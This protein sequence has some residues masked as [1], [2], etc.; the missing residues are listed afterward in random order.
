MKLWTVQSE[1]WYKTLL[2]ASEIECDASRISDVT[3]IPAYEWMAEQMRKRLGDHYIAA[4]PIWAWAVFEGKNKRPDLR[5]I[6]FRFY[7]YPSVL[8]EIEVPD[9]EI[10]LSDEEEWNVVMGDSMNGEPDD[11]WDR[12]FDISDSNGEPK[13]FV[14]ACFGRLY[15]KQVVSTKVFGRHNLQ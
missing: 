10:L 15:A 7:K 14:Q 3:F 4:Y 11:N 12:I 2:A 6:E 8:L 5:G 13:R 1:E 9:E